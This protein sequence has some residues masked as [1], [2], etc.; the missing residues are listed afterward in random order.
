MAKSTKNLLERD[1][2]LLPSY[3]HDLH[4]NITNLLLKD[5]NLDLFFSI[6]FPFSYIKYLFWA[7]KDLMSEPHR[8]MLTV[9]CVNKYWGLRLSWQIGLIRVVFPKK[10]I[11]L[12]RLF[13]YINNFF[14]QNSKQHIICQ[15]DIA[16]QIL[17][18]KLYLKWDI[19]YKRL[20]SNYIL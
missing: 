11:Q 5:L 15:I 17:L 18:S 6:H 20:T 9:F 8:L 12:L 3:L 1:L 7:S 13:F 16:C 19:P 2:I 14:D 4:S 10:W